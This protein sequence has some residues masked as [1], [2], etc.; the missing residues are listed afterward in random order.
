[1]TNPQI[2]IGILIAHTPSANLDQIQA[3]SRRLIQDVTGELNGATKAEW[4]FNIAEPT[5]LNDDEPRRPSD[6]LDEASLRMVEGPFDILVVITDVALY[7]R[8][9]VVVAGLASY[10]S[11]IIVVSTRKLILTPRGEPVRTLDSEP[12]RWNAAA[13][14]LH[15]LGHVLGINHSR[16]GEGIMAS[17]TLD[18]MR[19][20]IPHFTE[21]ERRQLERLVR[22]APEK[23]LVGGSSLQA[24]IFHLMSAARHPKEVL[25]PVLRNRALLL[26]LSLPSL[27][28]AA[29]APTFL[30]VFTAEIWDVGINMT[31]RVAWVFSIASICAATW[32]LT[33]VHNLF[34]PRKEK[35]VVKEH[36]AVVNVLIFLTI[37]FASIGL[38]LLLLLLMLIIE[39][40]IF[41]PDLIKTWLTIERPMVSVLDRVRLAAFIST[42]GVLTGSLAGGLESRAVIRH[43][44][45]FQE[46][47]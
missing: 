2:N 21:H 35:R 39:F 31:D 4:V 46:E 12:V 26:P 18:E 5:R 25:L 11:R 29:V 9:H 33:G 8:K 22:H 38:F 13:L 17:F 20:S 40:Y 15:L 16:H 23:E 37:F 24:L 32:Y 36:M 47:P 34:Y 6:F 42:I 28:T 10:V 30:L 1:M 45:L 7:S 3:F 41:P 14:L 19:R 44:A 43:L 27:A